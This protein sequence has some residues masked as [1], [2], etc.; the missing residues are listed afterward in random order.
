[1]NIRNLNDLFLHELQET[2]VSEKLILGALPKMAM[3]S[4]SAQAKA[5]DR[6]MMQTKERIKRLDQIFKLVDHAPDAT[7]RPAMAG[8]LAEIDEF[9]GTIEDREAHEAAIFSAVQTLRHYLLARYATLVSWANL[10]GKPESAKLLVATLEEERAALLQ[11][12]NI[13]GSRR[14]HYQSK[15]TSMGERLTA[16]FDRK[17]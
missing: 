6:H 5:L 11:P 2:H 3:S 17:K 8:M 9:I 15:G 14:N 4:S 12:S 1:M 10:L 16:L 13:A 7:E